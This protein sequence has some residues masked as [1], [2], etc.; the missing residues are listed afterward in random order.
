MSS[1]GLQLLPPIVEIPLL[2]G[3]AF[4]SPRSQDSD[5]LHFLVEYNGGAQELAPTENADILNVYNKERRESPV[6]FASRFS[7]PDPA[8]SRA[9]SFPCLQQHKTLVATSGLSFTTGAQPPAVWQ[10]PGLLFQGEHNEGGRTSIHG[11]GQCISPPTHCPAPQILGLPLQVD[12]P[13]PSAA[14]IRGPLL[15]GSDASNAGIASIATLL[16]LSSFVLG[17]NTW[18]GTCFDYMLSILEVGW[19][20]HDGRLCSVHRRRLP[21]DGSHISTPGQFRGGRKL[22][23]M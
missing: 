21:C 14:T 7:E 8:L 12:T 23:Q 18:C 13:F 20:Q 10:A 11:P 5:F 17:G 9:G 6:F 2:G 19:G 4:N 16:L 3:E 1:E 22:Q 15:S